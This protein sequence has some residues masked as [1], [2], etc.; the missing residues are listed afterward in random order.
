MLEKITKCVASWTVLNIVHY[1]SDK[2]EED[3]VGW[4]MCYLWE[5]GEMHSGS[6]LDSLKERDRLADLGVD[7]KIILK[8]S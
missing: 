7:G 5:R 3:E 8:G 6:C 4:D 1:L 2:V